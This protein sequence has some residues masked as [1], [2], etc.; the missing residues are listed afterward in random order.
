MNQDCMKNKSANLQKVFHQFNQKNILMFG[1][2]A[3]NYFLMTEVTLI[4]K[5]RISMERT[6]NFS[7][8]NKRKEIIN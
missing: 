4:M 2:H 5:M 8:Q 3:I 1:Y 6:I 7:I